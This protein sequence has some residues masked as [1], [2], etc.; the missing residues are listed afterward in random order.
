MLYLRAPT[1][2]DEAEI[3]ECYRRS[4]NLHQPW[5]YE[6][7]DYSI[8]LAQTDR[9]FLCLQESH[10]IVGTFN[11]SNIVRGCFHSAYL[12]YEVFSPHQQKGYMSQGLIL[13]NHHAFSVLNLHRLE[14]NVQPDNTHSLKL[15]SSAGFVKEG[16][17]KNYLNIGN[18]GWRDHERWAIVNDD[19]CDQ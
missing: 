4:V 7:K 16:Y 13:T 15:L 8:Y 11:I 17:S 3:R 1:E 14:A 12:G 2:K 6:P 9:L 5:A 18:N 19:W 10:E